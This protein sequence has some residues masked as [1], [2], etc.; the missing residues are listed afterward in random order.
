LGTSTVPR[1]EMRHWLVSLGN[2]TGL[3]M[4]LMIQYSI[5]KLSTQSRICRVN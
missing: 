2:E 3:H 4:S 1:T 5:C